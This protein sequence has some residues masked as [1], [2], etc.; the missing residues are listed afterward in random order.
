MPKEYI[1]AQDFDR[2]FTLEDGS[3]SQFVDHTAARLT[4]S[5]ESEGVALSVVD[6]AV[7]PD[8]MDEGTKFLN[9]DRNGCNRMI[10]TLRRARDAAFGA[11]A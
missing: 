9:L 3:Q 1:K 6:F 5:R 8:G 11:D 7:D 2:T 4:W 10:Q